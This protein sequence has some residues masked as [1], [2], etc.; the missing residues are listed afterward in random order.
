MKKRGNILG[1]FTDLKWPKKV[2]FLLISLCLLITSLTFFV[3][4]IGRPF[5]GFTLI[6]TTDGWTVK[7]VDLYGVA[8]QVSISEGDR[9]LMIDN[10]SAESI[11]E[12]YNKSGLVV[13]MV[14]KQL[15]VV[16]QNG[17]LKSA[18]LGDG[19][20]SWRGMLQQLTWLF[21]SLIF[22][23]V[24]F[25]AFLKR[26]KVVASI[27]LC[28]VGLFFGLM[29]SSNMMLNAG[30]SKA[31][32]IQILTLTIGP[33]LLLH[34]F[35]VLPEER[36]WLNSRPWIYSVYIVP[37][38]TLV[39]I[40]FIGL[41][42]DQPVLWFLNVRYIEAGIGFLAAT[43]AAVFN[44]FRAA[45]IRTRQQMKIVAIACFAALIPYSILFVFPQAIWRQ[46]I[47][48]PELSILL[49]SFIPIGMGYAIVTKKLLDIDIIIRRGVIYGLVTAMIAVILAAG[50]F[51]IIIY[52][53][54]LGVPEEILIALVLGGIATALVGPAKNGVE[55]LVDKYF[56]K[57]RYDYR[58]II[59]SLA[60]SL[61]SIKDLTD[62]S[63]MVVGTTVNT[64]NLSGGCLLIK[65]QAGSYELTAY[66]GMF[67]DTSKRN[68]LLRLISEHSPKIEFPRLVMSISSDLAFV[69]PL[70]AGD[71]EIGILCLSPKTTRQNF[72]SN[73]IFLIQGIASVSGI[74]LHSA[75]L[76][77]ESSIKD[78]FISIASHE[79]RTP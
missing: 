70:K 53:E 67:T 11:L 8:S 78:T 66:Q 12:E 62:I 23:I 44:Y 22:W 71:V 50:I 55:K 69:I 54:S 58:Q 16:D 25:Y 6:M 40:P 72:S 65:G 5:M 38:I 42:N 77:H 79:L 17:R 49:A 48:P 51:P 26:P 9:P 64:L 57:D 20:L 75:M 32:Y 29:L 24:G 27:L 45:S 7:S 15:T 63:R 28:L 33:W 61:N 76:M 37:V 30:L 56:Y 52:R 73:D 18:A 34:F 3:L 14:F 31:A 21:V 41:V 36:A 59:Q 74:A 1:G 43:G 60:A 4:S 68:K 2:V 13:S 39:L 47:L 35:L 19:T 10:R 46:N